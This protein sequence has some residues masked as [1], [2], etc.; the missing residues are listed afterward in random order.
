MNIISK[1]SNNFGLMNNFINLNYIKVLK[2]LS[3]I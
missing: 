2:L 1:I 3:F